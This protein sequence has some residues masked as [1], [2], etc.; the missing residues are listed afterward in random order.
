MRRLGQDISWVYML[1]T[2]ENLNQALKTNYSFHQNRDRLKAVSLNIILNRSLFKS[3]FLQNNET[4]I[5]R[6][7]SRFLYPVHT[8]L[9]CIVLIVLL[10]NRMEK[11]LTVYCFDKPLISSRSLR[12][13]FQHP[14]CFIESVDNIVC[15]INLSIY[16]FCVYQNKYN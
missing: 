13:V 9:L 3:L 15:D 10:E 1:A 7:T 8:P 5:W 6:F 4:K 2:R 14:T 16:S 11:I 12:R